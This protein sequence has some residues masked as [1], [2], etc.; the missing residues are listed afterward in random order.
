MGAVPAR[1]P[2]TSVLALPAVTGARRGEALKATWENV[3]LDCCIL[4]VPRS[5][6]GRTRYIPLSAVAVA[7][8]QR[9]LAKRQLHP[10]NPY[11]FPS[12]RRE[13][14]PV[15]GVRGAWRR[16]KEAAGC[17]RTCVSTTCGTASQVPW[18]TVERL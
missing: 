6:S 1:N 18:P 11:V 17:P 7:I 16:A 10:E 9:Q 14:Q 15:E 3:D 5:K 8:L 12:G 13:G 4:A 2:A